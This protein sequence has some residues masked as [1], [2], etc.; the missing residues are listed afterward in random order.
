MFNPFTQKKSIQTIEHLIIGGGVAGT[1]AA[2]TIRANDPECSIAIISDEPYPLYSRIMLSKPGFFLGKIPFNKIF[3]K[4]D[5]WYKDNNVTLLTGKKATKLH[6]KKKVVMLDDNTKLHYKKLLLATGGYARK[7]PVQGAEKKGVTYLRTLDHAKEIM[8]GVKSAKHAIAIGSGFI[9]FEMCDMLRRAGLEVTIVMLE[10][11]FW[12][13]VLDETSGRMIEKV[14][15]DNGVK[16]LRK[17]EV[18]EVIG[19]DMVSSV[20]LKDGKKIS[21]ELIVAGIGVVYD[22]DWLKRSHIKT[23]RGILTNEHL[24]TSA[25]DV[26]A[27]GDVTE[28]NDL[29]LE[30]QIQQV[31][32]TNSHMQGKT[33]GLNMVGTHEPFKLVSSYTSHGFGMVI[34]FVGDIRT[35]PAREIITRGSAEVGSY[36]RIILKNNRIIGA[37]LINHMQDAGPLAKLVEQQTNVIAHKRELADPNFQLTNLTANT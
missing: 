12:Y 7:W 8:E 29:I 30:E 37:T 5:T 2:E 9:S 28:F 34:G 14:L 18:E 32:W 20:T 19:D 33:A 6:T 10:P 17:A 27:A 22:L 23:N 21:C 16:I 36:G 1:T 15:R 26:W 13:P 35:T 31:S 4:K 25:P 24:E 11:Y 3:I